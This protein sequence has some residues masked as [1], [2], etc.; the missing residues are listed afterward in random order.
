ML[1]DENRYSCV[2][3]AGERPGGSAFS[4]ELGLAA[5][6]LVTVAG[7]S[8]LQRVMDTLESSP[9]VTGGVLCGP[10]K[11]VYD[12]IPEIRKILQGTAFEWIPPRTGPSAS[13]V[14]GIEK[15]D[16]F[17]IL[18]TAG[19]H[20]LLTPGIVEDFCN[21]ASQ[22]DADVVFGL[23]PYSLVREAFPE[24][25]RTVLRFS[26]GAWCGTNLFAI[27]TREGK[28]G[29]A[30][31]SSLEADR[32]RPWR[33]AR[34]ISP[35]LILKFFLGRLTLDSVLEALSRAMGCKVACVV[36]EDPRVAVDVDSVADRDLA[37]KILRAEPA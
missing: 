3:L 35:G 10:A 2:V 32:K 11:V 20:A 33:M 36:I 7:K 18:L 27:L 34:K 31:W 21:R 9:S 4:R 19:D 24:S 14:A 13:A 12:T 29:P 1:S 6:V 28:A 15:L 25:K 22:Q 17:P 8:S 23:T 26:D 5:S 16:R 37:E 30:F